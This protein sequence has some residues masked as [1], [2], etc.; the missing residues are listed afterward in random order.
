MPRTTSRHSN[1]M[2]HVD[3][4]ASHY[5][6]A[7]LERYAKD[8]AARPA[9]AT[10][11]TQGAAPASSKS[12]AVTAAPLPEN[13]AHRALTHGARA[14][15]EH[16]LHTYKG[17]HL[18][19][20]HHKEN[21]YELILGFHV[22]DVAPNIADALLMQTARS[23]LGSLGYTHTR[24]RI[25]TIGDRDSKKRFGRELGNF[26]RR[27]FGELPASTIAHV[28]T[29]VFAA[30]HDLAENGTDE[31][32]HGPVPIDY[33]NEKSRRHLR[34]ILD[35]LDLEPE[36]YEIDPRLIGDYT[37]HAGFIFTADIMDDMN[38][39]RTDTACVV[40]GGRYDP[41]VQ[42]H[43]DPDR[44]SAGV[45][46]MFKTCP[47]IEP[48]RYEKKRTAP[49]VTLIEIGLAPKLYGLSIMDTLLQRGIAVNHSLT[50]FSL[51]EQLAAAE[52]SG[53]RFVLIVGAHET[54]RREVIIRDVVA[55][56]QQTI[57][58][59]QLAAKLAAMLERCH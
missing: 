36:Q 33:L 3:A 48:Y 56:K 46:F 8:V 49:H 2:S 35:Y 14:L 41:Y 34:E 4:V 25:N 43:V 37:H 54:Q 51:T 55:E 5:G 6:F 22:V 19:Y 13:L 59:K 26:F 15:S 12:G 23:L 11:P 58:L 29:D 42:A 28:N 17:S 39:P 32:P 50:S 27:N 57:P 30:Y 47:A 53:T 1:L 52:Q 7:P 20:T 21:P 18:F 31:T 16:G 9:A 45:T 40:H 10:A 38:V 24:I 44:I